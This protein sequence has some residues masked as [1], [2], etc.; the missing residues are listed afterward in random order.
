MLRF[1][2]G[3][4]APEAYDAIQG[5]L[6]AL[7]GGSITLGKDLLQRD[8]AEEKLDAPPATPPA[9]AAQADAAPVGASC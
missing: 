1:Y 5:P 4:D 6:M 8:A 7:V 9:V 2:P 3:L